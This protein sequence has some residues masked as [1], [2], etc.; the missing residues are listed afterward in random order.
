MATRRVAPAVVAATLLVA[1]LALFSLGINR[2]APAPAETALLGDAA[3][4]VDRG[5][6]D[7]DR[8]RWPLFPRTEHGR[9]PP[10]PFYATVL[11]EP[12]WRHEPTRARYLAASAGAFAVSL[13]YLA[14]RPVASNALAMLAAVLL[15]TT[16]AFVAHS[17]MIVD[18][19][20]WAVPFVLAF[21][22]GVSRWLVDTQ[23][24]VSHLAVAAAILVAA[25][26]AQPSGAL[27]AVCVAGASALVIAAASP[28]RRE[29]ATTASAIAIV[30][31]PAAVTVLA[32]PAV[33]A[34]TFGAWLLHQ[35]HLGNPIA[36]ARALANHN[37]MRQTADA[38][39]DFFSP[40][41]LLFRDRAPALAGF[42]LFASGVLAVLGARAV[43]R[44]SSMQASVQRV[45]WLILGAVIA[46][47]FATALFREERATARGLVI[48]P[49][50]MLLA[51]RGVTALSTTRSGRIVLG[52]AAILNV[53]QFGVWFWRD[54]P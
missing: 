52:L 37:A 22:A 23:R 12:W 4:F 13:I 48:A 33:Y 20:V 53:A 36:W 43:V 31:A 26:Y 50:A 45:G 29:M 32:T 42:F 3:G 2:R 21:V 35:A 30:L 40:A 19:G 1:S 24:R 41:H 6:R 51:L 8:R 34:D 27:I 28:T 16:P 14:A 54:A 49:L 9:R 15:A 38:F 39:W 25:A 10:L 7:L 11:T 47:V 44:R 5:A 17:R 18:E 46:S